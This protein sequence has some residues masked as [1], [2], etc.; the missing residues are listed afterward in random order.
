VVARLRPVAWTAAGVAVLA[1]LA[2]AAVTTPAVAGREVDFPLV[3]MAI[4]A[5]GAVALL[6]TVD[7]AVVFSLAIVA[8]VLSGNSQ[9]VG[10]PIG[11]DR[12]LFAYGLVLLAWRRWRGAE[13]AVPVRFGAAHWALLLAAAYAVV[14]ALWAGTLLQHRG[15]Y[16]LLDRFGLVPFVMF[17]L[18]PAIF[19][20]ET[21]RRVLLVALVALGGYLGV[22]AVGEYLGIRALVYPK[23][24]L[25][26]SL[27]IHFGRA[28][29]PFLE[30]VANGLAL[31]MCGVA[32]ALALSLWRGRWARLAAGSV[33][34]LCLVGAILTLT[35]AVWLGAALAAAVT[36][37][38]VPE[39]RRFA[40]PAAVAAAGLALGVVLLV[41]GLAGKADERAGEQRPLWDR[42]NTNAAAVRMLAEKPI[43][44]V[45]WDHSRDINVQYLRQADYPL[46]GAGLAIHN[47]FLSQ[48][49]ELGLL[50]A[51]LWLVGLLLAVG[52]AIALRAPPELEPWRRAL[53][54]IA[55][56]WFVAANFGPLGYAF[57]TLLLWTWAGIVWGP[58]GTARASAA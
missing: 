33:L 39:L 50:G 31:G 21:H 6:A 47:V 37:L 49:T 58:R 41:P 51:L 12:L 55:I 56:V 11:P 9:Y 52:G 54:P 16:A 42:Y 57:P 20:T 22:T 25:D 17:L 10:L 32:A 26:P 48:A 38:W 46:T 34:A 4:A 53:A 14:S 43:L 40:A 29:G 7:V 35:R 18:A 8:A 30:A 19:R 1:V 2:A 45:G 24:I 36:L 27:G 15:F 23:Y 28:R 5:A 13:E 44:G 3:A